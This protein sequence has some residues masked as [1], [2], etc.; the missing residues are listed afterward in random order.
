MSG[1]ESLN[2]MI[3]YYHCQ[4]MI[5]TRGTGFLKNFVEMKIIS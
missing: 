3:N 2:L 4:T 1:M 5:R